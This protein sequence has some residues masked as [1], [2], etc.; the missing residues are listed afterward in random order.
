MKH[1]HSIIAAAL[2]ATLAASTPG[3][4]ALAADIAA[5]PPV[6][7]TYN[8]PAAKAAGLK[9]QAADL[10]AEEYLAL[11]STATALQKKTALDS[12]T[13]AFRAFES[14]VP[15]A[16]TDIAA[17]YAALKKAGLDR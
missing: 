5:K 12:A 4:V 17:A 2:A 15:G 3:S 1:R 9:W 16:K 11:P 7:F 10:A 13:T 8:A 14:Q 6:N